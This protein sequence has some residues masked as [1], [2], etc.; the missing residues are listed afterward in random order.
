MANE[1][2]AERARVVKKMANTLTPDRH[3]EAEISHRWRDFNTCMNAP[4][5]R[6]I[7]NNVVHVNTQR[8]RPLQSQTS[9]LH[10]RLN[11]CNP[12][13]H[14]KMI[15][16]SPT[17]PTQPATCPLYRGHHHAFRLNRRLVQP[18]VRSFGNQAPKLKRQCHA[19]P[20]PVHGPVAGDC[21][22]PIAISCPS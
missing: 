11:L 20:T 16:T 19:P 3:Y 4:G 7:M 2:T 13:C 5:Q 1:N 10:H 22:W 15:A 18:S 8:R 21:N 17:F 9:Q 14:C 12:S 6:F